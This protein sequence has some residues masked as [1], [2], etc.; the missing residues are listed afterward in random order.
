MSPRIWEMTKDDI[1]GEAGKSGVMVR[2]CKKNNTS[3]LCDS[4][5]LCEE[6]LFAK[7]YRALL[8]ADEEL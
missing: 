7:N 5:K 3:F 2:I 4:K 8:T 1:E 6:N